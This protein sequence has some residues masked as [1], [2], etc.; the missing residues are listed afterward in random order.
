MP[1]AVALAFLAILSGCSISGTTSAGDGAG[2]V[3]AAIDAAWR[4]HVDAAKRKDLDGA[5]A[6]YADDVVYALAGKRELRGKQALA[7]M[8]KLGMSSS[9]IGAVTHT[10]VA[11]RVDGATAHEIGSVQGDVAASGAPMQRVEFGYVAVWRRGDGGAWRIAHLAG[12]FGGAAAASATA[13]SGDVD[14]RP[15]LEAL[16]L[17]PRRQGRRPT[18]SIFTTVAAFEF[19]YARATGT[20]VRL[21][22]EYCNWAANAATGRRDDGDF[23]HFALQGF[24]RFGICRDELWP[25]G[26]SF[27][28]EATPSA[29]AL[30]DGGRRLANA[31]VRVRWIRP[32]GGGAGLSPAQFDDV[33]ATLRRGWPVAAGSSHSRVLVGYRADAAA[34]GGGTFLTLDSAVGGFAEVP[35][36][37]VRDQVNDAFVVETAD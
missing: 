27:A 32:I 12:Q 6:I 35:A 17:P 7:A 16:G 11:L 26:K 3:A 24:E 5:C 9:E 18:C 34:P 2:G 30:V 23:F 37:F 20:A 28:A 33:L 21:S 1:R 31:Q 36:S 25:Y 13:T 4:E 10:T 29:D 19:A 8:E 15:Q 22:V 14:L